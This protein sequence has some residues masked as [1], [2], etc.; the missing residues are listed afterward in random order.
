MGEFFELTVP[1][2]P[3]TRQRVAFMVKGRPTVA[4]DSK[5]RAYE[6]DVRVLAQL[7]MAR[8]GRK[9]FS[10]A[11][12]VW[13]TAYLPIPKSWSKKKQD[14]ALAGTVFPTS[15]PDGDNLV[16]AATDALKGIVWTDDAIL[17]DWHIR[18][19]YAATPRLEMVVAPA[20]LPL[21]ANRSQDAAGGQEAA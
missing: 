4:V 18:K 1:G 7:E 16:K 13:I 9:L 14:G 11:T 21:D 19:R 12:E 5:S 2:K 20:R 10:E 6:R 3:V 15:R 8:T 17:V